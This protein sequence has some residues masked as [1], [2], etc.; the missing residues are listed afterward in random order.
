MKLP[1][2]VEK[3]IT[4]KTDEESPPGGRALERVKQFRQARG[5]A[6]DQTGAGESFTTSKRKSRKKRT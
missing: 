3:Q 2:K 1:R 5:M 6:N 4:K